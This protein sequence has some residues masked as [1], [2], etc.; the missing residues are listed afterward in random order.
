MFDIESW[1]WYLKVKRHCLMFIADAKDSWA[2]W[3]TNTT[4]SYLYLICTMILYDYIHD[5]D[6]DS[7]VYTHGDYDHEPGVTCILYILCWLLIKVGIFNI[8]IQTNDKWS[9]HLSGSVINKSTKPLDFMN[10][11]FSLSW[12]HD[13][14]CLCTI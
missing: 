5:F 1:S 9:K 8:I 4:H 3:T 7:Q 13:G 2:C 11:S 14:G 6:S 10:I 12:V